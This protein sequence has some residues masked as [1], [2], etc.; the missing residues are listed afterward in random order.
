VDPEREA[1]VGPQ[2]GVLGEGDRVVGP[3]AV[4]GG[5]G[6]EDD[7]VDAGRGGGLQHPS[8]A[9]DVDPGHQ[10]LV[11]DGVV[12]PGQ[13]DEDVGALEQRRQVGA[14]HV[15][16]VE[17]EAAGPEAR[18]PYVE[19][20][21]PVDGGRPRQAAEHGLPEEPRDAGDHD[22]RG[23]RHGGGIIKGRCGLARSLHPHRL[24]A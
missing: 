1:G 8:G 16:E 12:D 2:R 5:A 3:G 22:G 11:R 17:L 4:D 15:D 6:D 21:Q 10:V 24:A 20:H 19:A 13:V 23:G 14:G 7:L 9:A 18:F